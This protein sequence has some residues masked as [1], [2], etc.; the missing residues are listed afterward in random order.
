MSSAVT[1]ISIIPGY[2]FLGVNS[3]TLNDYFT[4]G[5]VC[6]ALFQMIPV[7]LCVLAGILSPCG[8]IGSDQDEDRGLQV[9]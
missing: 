6:S 1:L 9:F 5:V 4:S 3:A 2:P 7:I 8:G